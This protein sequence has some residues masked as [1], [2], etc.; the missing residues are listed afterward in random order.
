MS[1]SADLLRQA[2]FRQAQGERI[3]HPLCVYNALGAPTCRACRGVAITDWPLHL[4]TAAHKKNAAAIEIRTTGP[5]V[6]EEEPERVAESATAAAVKGPTLTLPS[7][8]FDDVKAQAKAEEELAALLPRAPETTEP[9]T[10]TTSTTSTT[11]TTTV[12]KRPPSK[13]QH[14]ALVAAHA[15]EILQLFDAPDSAAAVDDVAAA[16][17]DEEAIQAVVGEAEQMAARLQRLAAI[18]DKLKRAAPTDDA[19]TTTN[20][21]NSKKRQ[22]TNKPDD[23]DDGSLSDLDE[24]WRRRRL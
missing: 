21:N 22:A 7:G 9:T 3:A 4:A 20:N 23:D 6:A 12:T 10:S 24:S 19:A 8:F 5:E 1:S 11:I 14:A 18:K 13:E 17:A 15:A 16:A 2:R